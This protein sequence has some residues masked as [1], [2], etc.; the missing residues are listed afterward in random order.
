[1]CCTVICVNKMKPHRQLLVFQ[2]IYCV[3]VR[4]LKAKFGK[5]ML[6]TMK[7]TEGCHNL[8]RLFA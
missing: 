3:H 8:I 2:P 1:M 6:I 5:Q 7:F 4:K